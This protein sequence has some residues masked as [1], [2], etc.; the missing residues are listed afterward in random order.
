MNPKNMMCSLLAMI[1]APAL[2]LAQT[3]PTSNAPAGS[4]AVSGA[5]HDCI[6]IVVDLSGSMGDEMGDSGKRKI[7]AAKQ[8]LRVVVPQIPSATWVGIVV[9]PDGQWPYALAP[10]DRAK[11]LD[12]INALDINGGTPIMRHVKLGA[13]R[14]L[15]ERQ[16][17][18]GYGN[19]QL[20]VV[21]DGQET[22]NEGLV[23]PYARDVRQRGLTFDVIGVA[24]SEDHALK[25][26]ANS[27]RDP[28]DPSSLERAVRE[29]LAERI[30]TSDQTGGGDAFDL[31]AG[32]DPGVAAQAIV[33]LGKTPNYPIGDA[34][35]AAST[36]GGGGSSTSP[37]SSGGG[38]GPT[39]VGP[40]ACGCRQGAE[41]RS[42]PIS[43]FAAIALLGFLRSRRRRERARS[44]R[45]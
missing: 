19:Y 21:T 30:D 33:A 40:N 3:A 43:S 10:L 5:A 32:L 39:S 2:A 16:K 35:P 27:Y 9:T 22:E 36:G 17:Q 1:F 8:A 20:L 44:R 38:G 26:Y 13:D 45:R 37:G 14:L 41:A 15:A 7:D 42:T 28:A 6:V 12:A 31:V 24:M 34:P 29:V 25:R 11:V 4:G 23:E 18:F